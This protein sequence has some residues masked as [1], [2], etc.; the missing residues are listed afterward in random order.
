MMVAPAGGAQGGRRVRAA[1]PG[2][3]RGAPGLHAGRQRAGAGAADAGALRGRCRRRAAV[4]ALELC[5]ERG[6]AAARTQPAAGGVAAGAPGVRHLHLGLHRPAQGRGGAARGVGATLAVAG[7]RVRFG[8]GD[9]VPCRW[10]PSRSTS[11]SSR[12]CSPCWAAARV[13]VV[14]ARA[15]PDVPRLLEEL[16]ACTRAARRAGAMRRIVEEVRATPAGVLGIRGPAFVGGD[17]VPPTCWR[18]CAAPSRRRM[19]NVSTAPRRRPSSAPRTGWA[20]KRRRGSADR[21]GRWA[22]RALY[23]LDGAGGAGAR[24]GV[25]GRAVPGRR[26]RGARLPGPAGADGGA[27]RPRPVQRRAGRAA[28]PHGRPGALAGGRDAGVPG[29]HGRPGEGARLPHRA[30]RDR[31]ACS[32]STPACARRWCWRARTRRATSGWWPTWRATRRRR[33]GAAGAPAASACRSTWC[34]AAFVRARGAAADAE[35]QGGPQGAARARSRAVGERG[36][37][38]PRTPVEEVLA[39][40][41]ARGAAAWSG[42]ARHDD[43]FELGGHSLLATRVVS[44]V[45]AAVR[46]GAPAADGVRGADGGGAGRARGGAAPRRACR[47]CRRSCRWTRDGARCRSRSRSSGS[48]SWT[49]WSRG[50]PSTTC[51]GALRLGGALDA[52]ALERALGEIVR[53]ARGAA[54]A[55]SPRW[56]AR[57]CR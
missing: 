17:A 38:A 54:D 28:V 35:R 55:S 14:A 40:I 18:R 32:P 37:V 30:G 7:R 52:A 31:G 45:R 9:R 24:V 26:R 29:P 47:R 13:R 20:A 6:V 1:G 8:A 15:R 5:A 46:G 16:A 36:Y 53:R 39:A 10:P 4:S 25:A 51:P 49:S 50:A 41:W 3:S 33:G 44:R 19:I 48:G 23:V 34:P 27:L 21:R 12:R 11:R 42:W 43:F 56:T 2:V 57:R 22:T